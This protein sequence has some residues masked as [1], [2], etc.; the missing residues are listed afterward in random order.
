MVSVSCFQVVRCYSYVCF[1]LVVVSSCNIGLISDVRLWAVA[2]RRASFSTSEVSVSCIIR[3]CRFGFLVVSFR[4]SGRV[5]SVFWSCRL[6][7]VLLCLEI[8][9]FM[10]SL[11][12]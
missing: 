4:F 9:Y 1:C 6:S 11:Q 2:L 5:V 8:K 12:L 10:L 3:V 7:V